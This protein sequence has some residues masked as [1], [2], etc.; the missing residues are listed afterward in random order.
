MKR[1]GNSDMD[2]EQPQRRKTDTYVLQR[3][4][5]ETVKNEVNRKSINPTPNKLPGEIHNPSQLQDE[6]NPRQRHFNFPMNKETKHID[7]KPQTKVATIELQDNHLVRNRPQGLP[8]TQQL[9]SQYS[10]QNPQKLQHDHGKLMQEVHH[11]K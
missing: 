8:R 1:N 3:D 10:Y 4:Q 5:R 9:N 7:M 6:N 2:I 11:M